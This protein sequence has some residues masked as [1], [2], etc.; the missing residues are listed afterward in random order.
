[1]GAAAKIFTALKFLI[2][3][4]ILKLLLCVAVNYLLENDLDDKQTGKKTH[5][6]FVFDVWFTCARLVFDGWMET[7]TFFV[8]VFDSLVHVWYL[9]W[10]WQHIYWRLTKLQTMRWRA[11]AQ[12]IN[13]WIFKNDLK[14]NL[15]SNFWNSNLCL[16]ISASRSQSKD[17][18]VE[19]F[20]WNFDCQS[21]DF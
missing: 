10:N 14:L 3:E 16:D 13:I 15:F 1:M 19:I 20:C 21:E 4:Q 5:T 9:F 6:F 7:H 12:N 8:F 17:V 2:N 18:I 11:D